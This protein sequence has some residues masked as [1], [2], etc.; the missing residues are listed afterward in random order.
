MVL[1]HNSRPHFGSKG[2]NLDE[3]ADIG[4]V[5]MRTKIWRSLHLMTFSSCERMW[6]SAESIGG[7][8]VWVLKTV[9]NI[10]KGS[11]KKWEWTHGKLSGHEED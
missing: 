6:S 2:I 7:V 5:G 3:E 9:E 4:G 10:W 11:F 1:L 8:H